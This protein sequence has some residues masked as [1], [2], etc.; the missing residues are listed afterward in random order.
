MKSLTL[1]SLARVGA[2]LMCAAVVASCGGGDDGT[3]PPVAATLSLY[4][5]AL[6][7]AGSRNGVG[8]AAQFNFPVDVAQDS[9]GS[10][11]VADAGN[12]TVRKISVDGTVTTLAGAAGQTGTADGAGAS[13]RFAGP[14]GIAVDAAGTVYVT[15]NN[16]LRKI[17][18]AGVVTTI[19]GAP[20][21]SGSADGN[22]AT[23]RF[24]G[25]RSPAV[26]GAGNVYVV[27]G[28]TVRKIAADG[29]VSTFAGK[30][31]EAGWASG[32]GAQTRFVALSSVAVDGGGNV[33]AA[34][35]FF[36]G[37]LGGGDL[38]KFDSQGQ[39]LPF[40]PNPNRVA[41]VT[42]PVDIAADAAG[43]VYVAAN[44]FSQPGPNFLTTFRSVLKITPDGLSATTVAGGNN[45]ARTVDG[46]VAAS[47][48]TDPRAVAVGPAG[49][50]AVVETSSNAIRL[51]DTQQG[52]VTTVA[53]GSGGGDTD[54]AAATARFNEPLG[55]AAGPDGTLYVA[56]TRNHSVRKISAAG[57][58]STLA[59][60][61]KFPLNVAIGPNSGTLYMANS[62][63][64][65]GRPLS[66]IAPDGTAS[67]FATIAGNSTTAL[68]ADGAGNV[69]VSENGGITVIAPD[70]GKRVLAT[71]LFAQGLAVD[72]AGKVYVTSGNAVRVVD[73]AGRVET[74]AGSIDK[75]S[76]VDGTGAAAGFRQAGWLAV[77]TAGNIYVAD[78]SKIRKVTPQGI[79]TTV[80]D[81]TQLEGVAPETE[82]M[83]LN[84]IGGLAW[85]D[86]ALYAT[87]QNAVIK[88]A[89]LN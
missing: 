23:A 25:P 56:D 32:N 45:D 2:S 84:R 54:G 27:D 59:R 3:A 67:S 75:V 79:V 60:G 51:I 31:G 81:I 53:G 82:F 48:F 39:A 41:G 4:A 73:A 68:A 34:Q 29:T 70:G 72:A 17:S 61:F 20:G 63:G 89:P 5:G 11:Y 88:I 71:G 10:I 85:I 9:A 44:G 83:S 47:R 52:T 37:G 1:M 69:Y 57:A 46:T 12:R 7:S 65:F 64:S 13:A 18:A 6:R 14:G 76:H 62:A 87:V 19:A 49:R 74:R 55:L 15:D 21:Q 66:A 24:Q 80:A 58:V 26:D 33:Y 8:T 40:G 78:V 16:T 38:R 35:S 86:G 43:N 22:A 77:D 42:Y 50:I 36:P 28:Q 30:A